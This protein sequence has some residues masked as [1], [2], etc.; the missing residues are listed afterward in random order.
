MG[1]LAAKHNVDAR[2]IGEWVKNKAKLTNVDINPN[3]RKIHNGP[4]VKRPNIESQ[5]VDWIRQMRGLSLPIS[6][7]TVAHEAMHL[8]PAEWDSIFSARKWVYS[9]MGRNEI[10]F[11]R[12]T[13]NE[14]ALSEQEM[15]RLHLDY[16]KHVRALMEDFDISPSRVVNFDET[17]CH[18]DMPA[19]T[20]IDIRGNL[21]I[22]V[23]TKKVNVL[24]TGDSG[25]CSVFLAVALDGAKLKPLV[26]FKG[27]PGAT[28][29]RRLSQPEEGIDPR[30]AACVQEN[31][32]C[33][34]RVMQLYVKKCVVPFV[35]K[36]DSQVLWTMDNF[37]SHQ[38]GSVRD[39]FTSLGVMLSFLPPNSTSKVQMLDVGINKPFKQKMQEYFSS[40]LIERGNAALQEGLERALIPKVTRGMMSK[41]I[42]DAWDSITPETIKNTAV[43]VGFVSI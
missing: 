36:E 38:V 18:F 12:K 34:S 27:K 17:G 15:G 3:S 35:E 20:T 22:T 21:S 11:R 19:S 30:V 13:H 23:G 6:A 40:F 31:A 10:S 32:Y 5:L 42:A 14:N 1:M 33:D 8:M 41:W 2:R 29:E 37:S 26:V 7:L 16:V 4:N 25:F 24:S 43:K 39:A 9:M 28:V